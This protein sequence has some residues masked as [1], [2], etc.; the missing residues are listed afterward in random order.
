MNSLIVG[1]LITVTQNPQ[2]FIETTMSQYTKDSGSRV[3]TTASEQDKP[4]DNT[5]PKEV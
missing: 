3:F 4:D 1:G 5:D 2:L